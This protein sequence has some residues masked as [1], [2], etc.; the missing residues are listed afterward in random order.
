MKAVVMAGG[1]GSRLRP[2]TAHRPKPLVP[3]GNRPIMEHLIC[4]LKHQGITD[5]VVT[6]HYQAD[7]IQG[8][9]GDGSELGVQIEYSIED[10]PLGTAGSV[11]KARRMIGEET[12][13]NLSGD[14]LT[15]INLLE[16]IEFHKQKKAT[17]TIVLSRVSRPLEYGV[18]V[19]DES[20]R[21]TDFVEKPTWSEV[22]SDTVNTGIYICE[23]EVFDYMGDGRRVDWSHD[24]FPAMLK[25]GAPVYGFVAEGFWCDVG[26]LEQFRDAQE[27]LLQGVVRLE[28]PESGIG[29]HIAPDA[30]ILPPVAIGND[31]VVK[32]R[33]RIGP[34]TVLGDHT[35]VEEDAQVERSVTF[36]GVYIG[37]EANIQSA[38]IGARAII[39]KDCEVHQEAVIG[40]RCLLDVGS[41]VRARVKL[42]PDKVIERGSVV[43]MSL[44]W[45]NKWRG[46]LFR[47]L[48]V[49]GL[50]N[51]EITP[52]F[53][54][55]LGSAFG[56]CLPKGSRIVTSRDSTRSSRMI[57]RAMIASLV[58][59]G[60]DILDLRSAPAPVCRHFIRTSGAQGAVHV[61]KLPTNSRVT[62]VEMFDEQGAYLSRNLERKVESA[63]FR[64]DFVRADSEELG[65]IEFGTR[66]IEEY[67]HDFLKCLGSPSPTS[68]KVVCD[69]AFSALAPIASPILQRVGIES[70]GLNVA[71]DAKKAPRTVE[72]A[73]AHMQNLCQAVKSLEGDLGALLTDDGERLGLCTKSGQPIA[74]FA[75]LGLVGQAAAINGKEMMTIPVHTP[76]RLEK[77]LNSAG[78][79]TERSRAG[80]R[81]IQQ[82]ALESGADLYSDGL[83]GFGFPKF[84]A[85][86]DAAFALVQLMLWT[87]E[88]GIQAI[89]DS[90][91]H[92]GLSHQ[93]ERCPWEQKGVLMRELGEDAEQETDRFDGIRFIEGD[94]W[95]LV[96]PDPIEPLVHL[97]AEAESQDLARSR[98]EQLGAT[99]RETLSRIANSSQ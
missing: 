73:V 86:F 16:A 25:A 51:L 84:H 77:A 11:R 23:P 54:T 67:Q 32:S 30:V 52:D 27:K 92:F 45:G 19:T 5:I 50:S 99:V 72:E 82:H 74:G 24:V 42:W 26:T 65:V 8:R 80:V 17:A 79:R 81:A 28:M 85:G 56:S 29:S 43:T 39:K 1:E 90:L 70:I 4:H 64:E 49:A 48:G 97:F 7:E 68:A 75:L 33:A 40:D 91:P 9:F 57:K 69:F 6:L 98:V 37:P 31:V 59:V 66:A 20:G 60:C 55:R 76:Y 22:T 83:G 61:R 2:L 63:F 87:R 44:V 35:R 21:V 93:T 95:S 62:I 47:E 36:E 13:I 15:D 71:N 38:I 89:I 3:V 34:Y 41:V 10:S 18:V 88:N 78:L 53:A 12:F 94:D 96:L 58:S 14:A 46:N